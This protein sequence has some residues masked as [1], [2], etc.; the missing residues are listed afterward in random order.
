MILVYYRRKDGTIRHC[1]QYPAEKGLDAAQDAAR[2]YNT[3]Q[4]GEDT[5]YIAQYAD[6]S[7]EAYLFR[8]TV[9]K[10]IHDRESVQDLISALYEALDAARSL[11][12]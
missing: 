1:H 2:C 12:G 11:E 5:A 10:K 7:I 4:A 6:D 8:K 3:Q 9:E